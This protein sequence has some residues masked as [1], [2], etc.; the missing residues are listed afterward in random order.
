MR[1]VVKLYSLYATF[2]FLS[3]LHYIKVNTSTDFFFIIIS[4]NY[5]N[6]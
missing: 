2:D 3:T 4:I 1:H 5:L 6:Y